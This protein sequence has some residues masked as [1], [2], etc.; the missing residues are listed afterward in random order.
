MREEPRV[1]TLR[2]RQKVVVV[3]GWG[4]EHSSGC[5]MS[6]EFQLCKTKSSESVWDKGMDQTVLKYARCTP[7]G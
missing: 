7:S 4:R 6:I 2:D 3:R 5:V 1:E